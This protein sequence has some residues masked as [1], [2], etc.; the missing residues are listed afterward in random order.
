MATVIV[1]AAKSTITPT[2]RSG[3]NFWLVL[4]FDEHILYV[5]ELDVTPDDISTNI[6]GVA[7]DHVSIRFNICMRELAYCM[8]F[9]I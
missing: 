3:A 9:H 5:R 1:V 6:L 8:P 4:G 7:I 2:S